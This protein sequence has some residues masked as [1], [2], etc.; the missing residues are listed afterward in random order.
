MNTSQER[1]HII[2]FA[3][4]KGGVGKSTLC[5]AT[6]AGLVKQ[7]SRALI[8]DLDENQPLYDWATSYPNAVPNLTVKKVDSSLISGVL[9]RESIG[10]Y[11]VILLDL[12]GR[13][14]EALYHA[15]VKAD[16]LITPTRASGLDLVQAIKLRNHIR[17]VTNNNKPH[18]LL[19]NS[20][21]PLLPPH[22]VQ[23]FDQIQ[24]LK[25][26]R[27]ETLIY[28]RT[29]YAKQ[30]VSE[31]GHPPHFADQSNEAIRKT[32]EELNRLLDE[33]VSIINPQAT[34]EVIHAAA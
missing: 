33:I 19:F 24:H 12:A 27:F 3:S 18:R 7:G 23:L 4:P 11:D 8:L 22:Q 10:D 30:F 28:D 20:V 1:A 25:L 14:E 32:V 21:N 31:N 34:E 13:A 5:L 26:P 17:T 6:A 16:L 29:A 9:D 2:L 15:A